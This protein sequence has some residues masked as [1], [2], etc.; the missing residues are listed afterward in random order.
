[1]RSQTPRALLALALSGL[2]VACSGS[3]SADE[4]FNQ[5]QRSIQC[6][7]MPTEHEAYDEWG[8]AD[9]ED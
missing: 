6:S 9:F 5:Q 3:A 8:C 4:Q 2:A 1:M 7:V